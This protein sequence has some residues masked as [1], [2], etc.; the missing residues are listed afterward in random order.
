MAAETLRLAS[1]SELGF[2]TKLYS[3][4]YMYFYQRLC[5]CRYLNPGH[6]TEK[7][8]IGDWLPVITLSVALPSVI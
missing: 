7:E 5:I 4:L 2:N 6:S 3:L 8:G 1:H